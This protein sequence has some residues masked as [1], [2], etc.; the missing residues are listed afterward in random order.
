MPI[1]SCISSADIAAKIHVTEIIL[2]LEVFEFVIILYQ[3]KKSL[4]KLLGTSVSPFTENSFLFSSG[5]YRRR[6]SFTCSGDLSSLRGLYHRYGISPFPKE[7]RFLLGKR[8]KELHSNSAQNTAELNKIFTYLIVFNKG[9][10]IPKN[11]FC[12]RAVTCPLT[13]G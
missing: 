7:T 6:R 1:W 12:Q 3:I 8:G 13:K 4:N 10:N 11:Y 5:L 9:N 2:I